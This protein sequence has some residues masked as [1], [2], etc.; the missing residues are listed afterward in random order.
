MR[1]KIGAARALHGYGPNHGPMGVSC[2][3]TMQLPPWEECD[4]VPLR[5]G[6]SA[7]GQLLALLAEHSGASGRLP[8]SKMCG[9]CGRPMQNSRAAGC[10]VAS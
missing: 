6:C 3:P 7:A 5:Q 9:A 1:C 4:P 2:T 8:G 10:P